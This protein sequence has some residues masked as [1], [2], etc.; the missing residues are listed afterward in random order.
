MEDYE[1]NLCVMFIKSTSFFHSQSNIH[2][3]WSGKKLPNDGQITLAHSLSWFIL[4]RYRAYR[5][6]SITRYS[7][8]IKAKFSMTGTRVL[9]SQVKLVMRTCMPYR[10][11][12]VFA[13]FLNK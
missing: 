2:K 8:H 10:I 12:E 9:V 6:N 3:T 1:S 11:F 5:F 7:K 13:W 4:C